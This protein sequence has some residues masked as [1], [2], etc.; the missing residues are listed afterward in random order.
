MPE[1]RR[2]AEK[3]LD[4]RDFSTLQSR[5][6][7]GILVEPLYEPRAERLPIVGRG[8]VRWAILQ[9]VDDPDPER[10]NRQA[11][12]DLEGGADGLALRF[13]AEE[14]APGGLPADEQEAT[15]RAAL[16]GIHALAQHRELVA[17]LE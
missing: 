2:L 6:R 7:D 3:A 11:L 9:L 4:G 10:A 13:A 17:A 12:A 5:T 14:A 15:A 1:W 8:A 16:H